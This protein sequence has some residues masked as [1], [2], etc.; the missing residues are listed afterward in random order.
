[1]IVSLWN[2]RNLTGSS[3]ALH[4]DAFGTNHD[5][6]TQSDPGLL[7]SLIKMEH[8]TSSNSMYSL[9]L[10]ISGCGVNLLIHGIIYTP[11]VF[12]VIFL[13]ELHYDHP[14]QVALS[15][16][17]HSVVLY[18]SGKVLFLNGERRPKCRCSHYQDMTVFQL[19]SICRYHGILTLKY[20]FP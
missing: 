15:T 13:R 6:H 11:G 4:C 2:L 17:L 10:V 16:S 14:P 19:I 12:Y 3:A 9:V 7:V 8:T 20:P 1:M 5:L 18:G